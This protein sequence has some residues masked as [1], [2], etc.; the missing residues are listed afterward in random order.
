VKELRH[1]FVRLKLSFELEMMWKVII[2]L[3]FVLQLF[4][5]CHSRVFPATCG[6][7]EADND[8]IDGRINNGEF[9]A[10]RRF[11]WLGVWCH[12]NTT[13]KCFCSVNL[14]TTDAVVTAAHCLRDKRQD[15]GTYWPETSIHFGRLDLMNAEEEEDSQV[16]KVI[17]VVIHNDWKLGSEAYDADIAVLRLNKPAKFTTKIQPICLPTSTDFNGGDSKGFVVSR[18]GYQH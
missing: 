13:A 16:R 18:S 17:D 8:A 2:F 15:E 7:V 10:R 9:A 3:C 14:I 6:Q 4:C 1:K 11:P 5:V 12:G